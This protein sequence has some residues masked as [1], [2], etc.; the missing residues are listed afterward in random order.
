MVFS[1]QMDTLLEMNGMKYL[2]IL[3]GFI[4]DTYDAGKLC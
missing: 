4:K 2:N 1:N 3:Q